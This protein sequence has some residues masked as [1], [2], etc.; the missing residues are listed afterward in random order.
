MGVST[1][2]FV[3]AI[4]TAAA[5]AVGLLALAGCSSA[6]HKT[7]TTV[8]YTAYCRLMDRTDDV[9]RRAR[10]IDDVAAAE[11]ERQTNAPPELRALYAKSYLIT[12]QLKIIDWTLEH[13][14]FAPTFKIGAQP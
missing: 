13:C 8:D 11:Q 14:G 7:A 10:S 12:D 5:V 4:V 6:S 2:R 1:P 9:Y 3:L